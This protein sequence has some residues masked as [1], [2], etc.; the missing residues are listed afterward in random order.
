VSSAPCYLGMTLPLLATRSRARTRRKKGGEDG[1]SAP[2]WKPMLITLAA[3]QLRR[4]RRVAPR[5]VLPRCTRCAPLSLLAA[6]VLV[7]A[8]V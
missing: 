2:A 7:G 6:S 5:R 3:A 8:K 4:D 1:C